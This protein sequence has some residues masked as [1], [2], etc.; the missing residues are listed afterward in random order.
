VSHRRRPTVLRDHL[1]EHPAVKA[2]LAATTT[3]AAVPATV[4]VMRER[5][6]GAVYSLPGVANG[7]T[8]FAKR[9]RIE[10]ISVEQAVYE[11]ILP[12]LPLQTPRYHGSM[13][14]D[15]YGWI[16]VSDVGGERYREDEPE[17]RALAARW[18]ATMHTAAIGIPA[19]RSLPQAGPGRYLRHLHA[20][21]ERILH[22][23]QT[24]PFPTCEAE[25]L[26]AIVSYCLALEARWAQV[27]SLCDG[28]PSTLVHCDFQPKNVYLTRS[29]AGLALWLIDWE[30]AGFGPP[31][32]DLT[33]IDLRTYWSTIRSAWPHVTLETIERLALAG[34][35]LQW[36]AAID[37]GSAS[38][39]CT[40]APDRS[41]AV[42]QLQIA[43]KNLID[44]VSTAGLFEQI[45]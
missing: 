16:F 17:H 34:R 8:V 29:G 44:A 7:D 10:R 43:H 22:S 42:I 33:Q 37:W 2:W 25:S 31:A 20:G 6:V 36:S 1:D 4:L 12:H 27:E 39:M 19:V 5:V 24:W 3:H 11:H 32:V 41:D 40:G 45:R 26:N 9:S 21:R 28:V 18:L 30:M 38:L 23:L 15:C 35:V 14:N 13:T